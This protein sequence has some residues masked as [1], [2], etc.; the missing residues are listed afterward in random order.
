[1]NTVSPS[2]LSIGIDG[3][4]CDRCVSHVSKALAAIPRLELRGVAL[5]SARVALS[6][7]ESAHAAIEAIKAAGYPARILQR[8]R[9]PST[10]AT[11][12][13]AGGASKSCCC[14]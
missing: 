4:T 12:R 7:A 10:S 2:I 11:G 6:D 14:G 9:A 5:G 8:E 3:M 1:M 13:C